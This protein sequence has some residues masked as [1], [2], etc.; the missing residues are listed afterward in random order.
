MM[1]IIASEVCEDE[2]W[3]WLLSYNRQGYLFLDLSLANALAVFVISITK[4]PNAQIL[5]IF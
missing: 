4:N 1:E 3:E 5:D 2:K